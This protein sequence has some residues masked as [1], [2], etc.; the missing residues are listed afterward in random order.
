MSKNLR[1]NRDVVKAVIIYDSK[2]GNTKKVAMSLSRG[3]EAG[4]IQIDC[5]YVIDFD[6][7]KLNHYDLIGI[8]APTHYRRASKPVKSFLSKIKHLKLEKK[9]F[10]AFETR[11]SVF[12]GGSAAKYIL[13]RLRKM[14]L[15]IIFRK[16]TGVVINDEGPLENNTLKKMEKIGVDISDKLKKRGFE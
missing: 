7:S 11:T 10:F 3:L 5:V 12:L 8:G 2:F 13:K 15:N 4:N 1:D 14:K 6:I 16:I 9:Q